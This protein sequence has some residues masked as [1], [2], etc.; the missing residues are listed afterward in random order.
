VSFPLLVPLRDD[1]E[2]AV[3]MGVVRDALSRWEKPAL[4]CFSD[5]D[6]IFPWPL[7]AE[8]FT[9]LI[10]SAGEQ[11]RIR[12]AAHFLQEDAGPQIAAAILN[13][14]AASGENFDREAARRHEVEGPSP[15]LAAGGL[16]VVAVL[17]QAPVDLVHG[18]LARLDEADVEGL[19]VGH[20]VPPAD[21]D[22]RE[23]QVVV[24]EQAV[25]V[26]LALPVRAQAEVLL[27]EM[28]RGRHVV[29]GEVHVVELH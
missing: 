4:V 1:H 27:E 16:D 28:P 9:E 15:V 26:P 11:V 17:A 8:Q 18:L 23:H 12:N 5:L 10:P 2:G 19:G 20:G 3:A 22:Q 6:P 21:T 7:A 29:H 14:E 13:G 25:E 24:V